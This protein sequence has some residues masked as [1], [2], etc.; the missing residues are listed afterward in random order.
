RG[1]PDRRD[2]R[3]EPARHR[4]EGGRGDTPARGGVLPAGDRARP[5][6]L[7]REAQPPARAAAAAPRKVEGRA[8]RARRL[9]LRPRPRRQRNGLGL[10]M[11][12]VTFLTP[13]GGLFVLAAAIPLAALAATE[14]RSATIRRLF[15]VA[16]PRRRTLVPVV[17]AL[18][19]LPALVGVAA[20]QPIVV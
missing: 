14:R 13:V 3:H 20:A 9:R 15:T 7:R 11:L 2:R 10:L 17:V 19:A 4:P 5:V 18:V 6:E 12:A 16:A 1:E 8:R